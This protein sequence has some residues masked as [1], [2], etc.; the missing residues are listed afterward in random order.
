MSPSALM[1][2]NGFSDE[3]GYPLIG[4]KQLK[5]KSTVLVVASP[6]VTFN[7]Y[8]GRVGNLLASNAQIRMAPLYR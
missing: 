8:V 7:Y 2:C 1:H 3:N 6:V 4:E 5:K